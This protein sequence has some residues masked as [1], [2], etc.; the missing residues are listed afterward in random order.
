MNKYR[1]E[2][3]IILAALLIC[4]AVTVLAYCKVNNWTLSS[5]PAQV[6]GNTVQEE[7]AADKNQE[8]AAAEN[9]PSEGAAAEPA[10]PPEVLNPKI[11]ALGDSY[12][13]GY[14]AGPDYS[15]TKRLEDLLNVPVVNKGKVRQTT[16]NLVQRFESDV[17]AENPGRV[18]IFSGTGDALRSVG[19]EQFKEN[20]QL[21]VGMARAHNITPVL[22]LPLY[23]PNME[24]GIR[25]MREWELS[26]AQTEGLVVLDFASVLYDAGGRYLS[27][28]SADG[29]N[30]S[31]RGYEVMGDYAATVLK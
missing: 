20:I 23:Y 19:L 5:Q 1:L 7:S 11:V 15:W 24:A 28:L 4:L 6:A 22:A 14:P 21:L 27:G 17:A 10:G 18:I 31:V 3:Q 29:I 12:T 16:G 13:F 9:A 8:T 2:I 26:Y 30:P 25:S